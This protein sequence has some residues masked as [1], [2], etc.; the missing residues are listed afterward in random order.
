MSEERIAAPA[1][2]APEHL[3][4]ERLVLRR[5]GA[6]DLPDVVRLF[7]DPRVGAWLGGTMDAAA[8]RAA[9]DRWCAHWAAHG[10][11]MWIARERSGGTLAARG[12]PQFSLNDG[13][14]DVELG[15][16]TDP[17]RWGRG[18]A[19]EIA[20]ASLEVARTALGVRSVVAKTMPDNRASL[21]VIEKLGMREEAAFEYRG[22]PHV[23]YRLDV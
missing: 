23:L 12:G 20:V 17:G 5:P 6:D 13:F 14:A 21:R 18:F 4:T 8:A 1:R 9:F 15:W 2:W 19:T 16:V 22:L 7:G 3:E 11:G 10:F